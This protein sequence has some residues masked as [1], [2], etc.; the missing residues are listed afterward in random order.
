MSH[1]GP[2]MSWYAATLFIVGGW[3]I[4]HGIVLIL[5]WVR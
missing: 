4:G 1:E 5:K 2:A 3:M